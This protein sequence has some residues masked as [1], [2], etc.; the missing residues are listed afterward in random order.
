MANEL[1]PI[2]VTIPRVE[3]ERLILREWKHEDLEPYAQFVGDEKAMRFLG[4]ETRDRAGAWREMAGIIG[5]WALRGYGFWAVE[6]KSTGAFVGRVGIW[7]PEGWPQAE[8]GW[9]IMPNHWRKGFATEAGRASAQWAFDT[10]GF[11]DIVSLIAP[12]N[13]ASVGVAKKLGETPAG[14]WKIGEFDVDIWKVAREDFI[15][16]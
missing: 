6:E 1:T 14:K 4:G 13:E 15:A 12:G 10:L 8:V 16:H 9:S 7:E 3:T 11:D 5:H 2:G